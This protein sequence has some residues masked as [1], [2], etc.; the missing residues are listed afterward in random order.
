MSTAKVPEPLFCVLPPEVLVVL[1]TEEV[2]VLFERS[3]G[4]STSPDISATAITAAMTPE[5]RALFLLL[6]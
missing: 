5:S 3:P 6:I 2:V 1:L 4:V